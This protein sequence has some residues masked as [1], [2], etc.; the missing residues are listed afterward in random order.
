M[1]GKAGVHESMLRLGRETAGDHGRGTVVVGRTG[2]PVA[3]LPRLQ[4]RFFANRRKVHK[5]RVF[6]VPLSRR[7]DSNDTP[8][9]RGAVQRRLNFIRLKVDPRHGP[10]G[11]YQRSRCC[12]TMRYET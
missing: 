1:N 10:T 9:S 6:L 5:S 4:G 7:Q 12:I 11:R 2:Q 3:I 8:V